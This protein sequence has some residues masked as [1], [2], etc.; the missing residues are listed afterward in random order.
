MKMTRNILRRM[1]LKIYHA[2]TVEQMKKN[3]S[4]E[5]QPKQ[6]SNRTT[7]DNSK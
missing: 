6:D 4:A 1:E 3:P 5:T 2:M 7:G